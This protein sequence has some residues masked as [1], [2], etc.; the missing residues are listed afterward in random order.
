MASSSVALV[1]WER[2]V[3]FLFVTCVA[4]AVSDGLVALH[5]LLAAAALA[6]ELK[7]DRSAFAH[8]LRHG[9]AD[10]L[11]LLSLAALA[12]ELAVDIFTSTLRRF[13]TRYS[14]SPLA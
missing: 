4:L 7:V 9:L 14:R 5:A 10:P 13:R 12:V 1:T 8:F 6:V 2:L 11:A 3:F